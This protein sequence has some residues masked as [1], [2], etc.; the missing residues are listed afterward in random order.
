M[1]QFRTLS[2]AV[3]SE[4]VACRPLFLPC[5]TNATIRAHKM[6]RHSASD[7]LR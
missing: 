1:I 7:L 5:F 3:Y 6:S 2:K 4:A